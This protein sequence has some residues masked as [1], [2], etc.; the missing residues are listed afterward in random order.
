MSGRMNIKIKSKRNAKSNLENTNNK[1]DPDND[2]SVLTKPFNTSVS[3]MS[4][5][6]KAFNNATSEV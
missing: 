2:T 5:V 4:N 3:N 1:Y 6:I